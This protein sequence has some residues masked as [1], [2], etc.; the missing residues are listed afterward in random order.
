MSTVGCQQS[1]VSLRI[2]PHR[3]CGRG[4]ARRAEATPGPA[5]PADVQS[6]AA[7]LPNARMDSPRTHQKEVTGAPDRKRAPNTHPAGAPIRITAE[8][9]DQTLDHQHCRSR[10]PLA[11]SEFPS[12]P[13]SSEKVLS[14]T[15][16]ARASPRHRHRTGDLPKPSW[17]PTAGGL[18]ALPQPKRG[19]WVGFLLWI[20]R[21]G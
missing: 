18:S 8:A 11:S 19:A 6:S 12:S 21:W 7:G 2:H 17:K 20:C 3:Q 9:K 15:Q 10:S 1:G 13:S 16:P 14:R 4:G 5:C